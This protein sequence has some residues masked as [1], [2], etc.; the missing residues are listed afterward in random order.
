MD[1]IATII[2]QNGGNNFAARLLTRS[3]SLSLSL[4]LSLSL[5]RGGEEARNNP[6]ENYRE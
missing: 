1:I 2:I 5:G 4:P 6:V 3:L